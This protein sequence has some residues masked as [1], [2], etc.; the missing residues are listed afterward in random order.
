MTL[1][2]AD[3]LLFA[4]TLAVAAVAACS[5]SGDGSGFDD[6]PQD[7]TPT[8]TTG[9]GGAA[10]TTTTGIGGIE[11]MDGGGG[12]PAGCGPKC[13]LDG[14]S[15]LDCDGNVVEQCTGADGCDDQDGAC[16][17][18]C[19]VAVQNKHAV[20]CEYY[21]TFM[22]T[23]AELACF[24]AF[25][26]NTWDT[27]AHVA[28]E[29]AGVTLP[30]EQFAYIPSGAGPTLQYEP[31]DPALG[32]PPGEVVILFLGGPRLDDPPPL[33]ATCPFD[34][35][36]PFGA[37]QH[38][39][40]AIGAS[41]RITSDVPVVSY[42]IN[43]YGGGSAAVTAASLLLPTSVWDTD[44]VAVNVYEMD[45]DKPSMNIVATEDDTK[46]TLLPTKPVE[47]GGGIPAGPA[48]QPLS[49]TLQKGENAQLTQAE[50]LTGTIVKADKPVGFM[51]GP[52]CMRA[53]K[54]TTYCDHGEQMIPP[55]KALGSE[56]VGVMHRPRKS[57][58]ALWRVIGAVDGTQLSWSES[59]GGPATLA[60]GQVVELATGK[61]FV[62]HSQD[63]AHPFMLFTLMASN[64]YMPDLDGYGDPD[65]VISV[66][67]KQYRA[68]YVFFAD[69]TYP[70]TNLVI[71]RAKKDG[72]FRPVTLDCA[73]ELAGWQPVGDYEWTRVDLITHDFQDV[74]ACSTGRHEIG[75]E[76]PF[77]LWV[78]GW[79]SPE[80][81]DFQQGIFTRDVSYGYPG[82]MNVQPI[83]GVV[84]D[85]IPN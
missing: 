20:G 84:L 83:N 33:S 43:P 36:V 52:R 56:Y 26:A 64:G 49:F 57:E 1:R 75:S 67:P 23:Y 79:G 38:D 42:E 21:A 41:F 46:V 55:V 9:T 60:A 54:G 44:Y 63:D 13:T 76:A 5:A 65:F 58:P 17:N 32:I 39:K 18:A 66:P 47:G 53:P 16:K 2:L 48:N 51:A 8:P 85:T 34:S 82:G 50:A 31:F 6:T 45:I 35:A 61:P 62:V 10:T 71:V 30:I 78:W 3:K 28:V 68:S 11:V 69:P 77:G 59:V 70:E 19:D 27:P 29:Y 14:H 7:D 24:A 37:M 25:V 15:V 40:T 74:G 12:G 81:G 80:T 22:D 72:A 73:G 4:A